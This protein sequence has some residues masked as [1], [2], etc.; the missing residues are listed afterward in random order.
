MFN[1]GGLIAGTRPWNLDNKVIQ[2]IAQF[3]IV[4]VSFCVYVKKLF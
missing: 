1:G 4:K 2:I 3:Y